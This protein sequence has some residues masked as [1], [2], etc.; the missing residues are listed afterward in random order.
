MPSLGFTTSLY[1]HFQVDYYS[2]KRA[3]FLPD[4]GV[5]K[6]MVLGRGTHGLHQG[7]LTFRIAPPAILS[8]TVTFE[9]RLGGR[10][11]GSAKRYTGDGHRRVDHADPPGYSTATCRF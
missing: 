10:V 6:A 8:G 1:M 5:G 4:P 2:Y 11:L 7:G 9:W 3:R